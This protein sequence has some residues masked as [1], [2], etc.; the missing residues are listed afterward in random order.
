MRQVAGGGGAI[1]GDGSVPHWSA[2]SFGSHWLWHT[3]AA[4]D[5]TFSGHR[6]G[7]LLM[8]APALNWAAASAHKS[9]HET[10]YLAATHSRAESG[11]R[12]SDSVVRVGSAWHTAVKPSARPCAAAE[13]DASHFAQRK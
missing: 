6:V 9:M 1:P 2:Y 10:A 7:S 11:V 8:Q 5:A 13:H 4:P 12:A 3:R